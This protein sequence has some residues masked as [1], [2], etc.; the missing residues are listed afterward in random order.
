MDINEMLAEDGFSLRDE[1]RV[2]SRI[3]VGFFLLTA[4]TMALQMLLSFVIGL[5]YRTGN[6]PAEL[7]S[8]PWYPY[9]VS[10]LP[11]YLI[12]V[13]L[14]ILFLLKKPEP[15]TL[16]QHKMGIGRFIVCFIM[17]IAVMVAGNIIGNLM[18]WVVGLLTGSPSENTIATILESSNILWSFL[19]VVI[20]APVIEELLF[21]KLLID[22][23]VKYGDKT[24]ILL[25]GLFFALF[26]GN[27]YQFFYAFGLGAMFAF[28]YIRTGKL[29][30]TICLHMLINA[31]GAVLA[32]LILSMV[33]ETALLALVET[34]TENA[35]LLMERTLAVLPG[36]LAYYGYLLAYFG[37]AVAGI[38]LLIVKRKKF[39]VYPG[40]C[41]I[42]KGMGFKTVFLNAGVILYV[43]ICIAMFVMNFAV[44]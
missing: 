17:C 19:F 27:F 37:L 39:V 34:S 32:P 25:S 22:R 23:T 11:M 6:I 5:L 12:A 7:F 3:G 14:C 38:V 4:V 26:H 13:P 44:Q 18:S 16:E 15:K 43:L 1:R 33:D 10:L 29:K 8:A 21:R 42:P 40:A 28:V 31:I 9:V 24:A 36:L 30:Y 41:V 20:L 35:E 2:F